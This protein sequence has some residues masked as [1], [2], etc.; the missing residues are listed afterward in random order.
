MPRT[1]K[2]LLLMAVACV[3]TLTLRAQNADVN[4][5]RVSM[6]LRMLRAINGEA[7]LGSAA[8][9]PQ[10]V[11][12]L[13]GA[14]DN[15][16][17]G[18][19]RGYEKY[20]KEYYGNV[21]LNADTTAGL[22]FAA[23]DTR[24]RGL[25]Y[26]D[27]VARMQGDLSLMLRP[28][29]YDDGKAAD[30]FL[31]LRPAVRFL[32]SISDHLGYFLDLSNGARL[33]GASTLIAQTDPSLGRITKFNSEDTSFFDRYVGYM[34]YQS[35]YVRVR[36]GREPLQFGYS[37]IDNLVH[38]LE[39][40]MLDGLLLDVPYKAFRFTMT[41]SAANGVDTAGN[42]VPSKF[43]ATHRL[44]FDPAPWLSLAVND[45]IVYWG[46][47]LDLVYLNPLAFFVSAGLSTQER[48]LNDNSM[49]SFDAALRP[50]DG[51]MVYGTWFVDD[52]NYATIGDTSSAGNTNKW[53]WQVGV[54]QIINVG[55]SPLPSLLSLE[56]VKID[57][58]TY[59]HRSI[60]ASYTSFSAPLAYN[61][62]SNSDRVALQ[63]RTWFTPRTFVRVDLDYTRHG[64]N[65]LDSAGNILMGEHPL[66]PGV[67]APIGNVGGDILRGDGDGIQ[68]NRFLRGNVS[69]QRRIAVWFSAEW[70]HNILTDVR[71][72][73]TNRTGGNTPGSFLFGSVEVRVGY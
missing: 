69:H 21:L 42:A 7:T 9:W 25:N 70:W 48:N 26:A 49:I 30:P 64:E 46:R 67:T 11:Y 55:P 20:I 54:S 60:N 57:P 66:Y 24:F 33:T 4:A 65:V 15:V 19:Y 32:G 29:Y 40:P 1:I 52:L 31:L 37:P 44:A 63:W 53:A 56:Y 34:Q 17:A 27:G 23:T 16:G 8:V 36:F 18:M 38:S 13:G 10:S 41:H 2:H 71:F 28:G 22:L 50:F 43:V 73:Y 5:E 59:S 61:M 45:M 3:C 58:F 51:T 6:D 68:G 72:G 39:A 47:G 62:Q 12:V 35:E 14:E